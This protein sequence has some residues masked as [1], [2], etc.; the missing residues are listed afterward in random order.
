LALANLQSI[1]SPNSAISTSS[2]AD[3]QVQASAY[4]NSDEA[5]AVGSGMMLMCTVKRIGR[6]KKRE[7]ED[8]QL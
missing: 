8:S 2:Y 7:R 6:N 3:F 1:K 5:V 4:V